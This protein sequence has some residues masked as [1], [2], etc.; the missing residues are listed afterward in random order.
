M[1]DQLTQWARSPFTT[2]SEPARTAADS[3]GG[4]SPAVVATPFPVTVEG[5]SST[6]GT[7]VGGDGE[8]LPAPDF[9]YRPVVTGGKSIPHGGY[10]K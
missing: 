10:V 6:G 7:D 1:S 5:S 8:A 9:R 3:G 2:I 4:P